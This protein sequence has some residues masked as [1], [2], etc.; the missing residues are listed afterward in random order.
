[1]TL[2]HVDAPG[3]SEIRSSLALKSFQLS[4]Q[5]G[6]AWWQRRRLGTD[7]R[8]TVRALRLIGLLDNNVLRRNLQQVARR[9]P[10]FQ[11][12]IVLQDSDAIHV[13]DDDVTIM[14]VVVD[15]CGAAD[16]D[17]LATRIID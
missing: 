13:I 3:A 6:G 11:G 8:N 7:R 5:Q 1:V 14:P 16:F 2:R 15:L 9:H 12:A 17:D 10:I 4:K